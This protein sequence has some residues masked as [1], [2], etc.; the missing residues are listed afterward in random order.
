MR[1]FPR[2]A[3][4]FGARRGCRGPLGPCRARA[5]GKRYRGRYRARSPRLPARG[6]G[7]PWR[8]LRARSEKARRPAGIVP[9]RSAATDAR[10]F[11]ASDSLPW[12]SA[13][14]VPAALVRLPEEG[15]GAASRAHGRAPGVRAASRWAA[16]LTARAS[17]SQVCAT[18]SRTVCAA[19]AD[20][21]PSTS[22]RRPARPAPTPLPAS[23]PVRG[24]A[25]ASRGRLGWSAAQRA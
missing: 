3:R 12:G 25:A 1:A 20:A 13:A 9:F 7:P 17:V 11:V 22:R 8:P 14:R 6:A 18:P 4:H 23:A 21:A 5:R 19:A 24:L 16:K 15:L 10:S 2:G